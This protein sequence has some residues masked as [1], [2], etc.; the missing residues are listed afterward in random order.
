MGKLEMSGALCHSYNWIPSEGLREQGNKFVYTAMPEIRQTLTYQAVYS[1]PNSP[2]DS[3]TFV[4][5][6]QDYTK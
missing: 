6:T 5:L 4:D 2:P 1:P 3:F